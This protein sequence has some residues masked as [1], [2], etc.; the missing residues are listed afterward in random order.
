MGIED[1]P[2]AARGQDLPGNVPDLEEQRELGEDVLA[3]EANLDHETGFLEPLGLSREQAVNS[4]KPEVVQELEKRL[5]AGGDNL[6]REYVHDPNDLVQELVE[7]LGGSDAPPACVIPDMSAEMGRAAINSWGQALRLSLQAATHMERQ[8]GAKVPPVHMD[9]TPNDNTSL[10]MYKDHE[11]YVI[12]FIHWVKYQT[13]SGML[14]GRVV[15]PEDGKLRFSV[16][17]DVPATTFKN[18]R[19]LNGVDFQIVL[20]DAGVP[21]R[22]VKR[23]ERPVIPAATLRL[24]DMCEIAL[25]HKGAPPQAGLDAPMPL[26][27]GVQCYVCCS[28]KDAPLTTCAVC[29]MTYHTACVD[30]LLEWAVE[31]STSTSVVQV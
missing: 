24:K 30:K 6:V 1:D 13:S 10:L 14:V 9:G 5:E 26:A 23:A 27:A 17:A 3:P 31:A 16:A 15:T 4:C 29:L 21:M 20:S 18:K 8:R 11:A 25:N 28:F 22:Q 2:A 7:T 19:A 12:S